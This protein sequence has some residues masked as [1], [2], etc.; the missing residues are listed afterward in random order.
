MQT[1]KWVR[2]VEGK[3]PKE[4]EKAITN[5]QQTSTEEKEELFFESGIYSISLFKPSEAIIATLSGNG[6]REEAIQHTH[7]HKRALDG[8]GRVSE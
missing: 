8:R 2:K 4:N 5:G 7:A 1:L 3:Q 6:R